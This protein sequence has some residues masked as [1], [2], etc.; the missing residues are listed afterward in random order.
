ML[1]IVSMVRYFVLVILRITGK[2][3]NDFN[4]SLTPKK[5]MKIVLKEKCKDITQST[6][7]VASYNRNKWE[8]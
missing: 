1:A 4:N 3:L 8:H 7:K 5:N 6:L 2:S